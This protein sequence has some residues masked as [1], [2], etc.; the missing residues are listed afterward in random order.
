MINIGADLNITSKLKVQYKM[1][2]VVDDEV[3]TPLFRIAYKIGN[4]DMLSLL[5]TYDHKKDD[6]DILLYKSMRKT[7]VI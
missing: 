2:N 7:D 4:K 1:E 5:M 6:D 3:D